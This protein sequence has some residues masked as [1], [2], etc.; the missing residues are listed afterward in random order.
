MKI[1]KLLKYHG[2]INRIMEMHE[3]GVGANGIAGT[4]VDNG[5]KINATQV[6]SIID[7]YAPLSAKALPKDAAKAQIEGTQ[8]AFCPA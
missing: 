8:Q 7:T 3:A 6:Q 2:N 1:G 4:F 5:I